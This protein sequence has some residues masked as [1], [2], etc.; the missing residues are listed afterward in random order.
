ME[1]P[2]FVI[3]YMASG[4]TTFGRALAK[5]T[6]R[7]FI[8]LDFYIRQRFHR[9]VLELFAER[10][11]EGFRSLER[12]MLREAGEFE[13]VVIACGGGTPCFFDNMEF[14]RSRGI[15][16]R[17]EASQQRIVERLLLT[18][19]KRP[20]TV[21]KTREELSEFVTAHLAGRQP[22]YNQAEISISGEELETKAQIQTAVEK[23][24]SAGYLGRAN[25][26]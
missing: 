1:K 9:T 12:N 4:K 19:G 22:Y 3:G 5:A 11:E 2:I 13:N 14:M 23:F 10:G 15:T 7:E 24:L 8:D 17:L 18:P 25:D 20:L 6:G 16:V 21:G 26:A